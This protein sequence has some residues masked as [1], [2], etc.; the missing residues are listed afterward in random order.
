MSKKRK[1]PKR[2]RTQAKR[3]PAKSAES[4]KSTNRVKADLTFVV[5]EDNFGFTS[6]SIMSYRE[7]SPSAIVRELIQNSMDAVTE[8]GVKEAQVRFVLSTWKTADIPGIASYKEAFRRSVEFR[9][10]ENNGKQLPDQEQMIVQHIKSALE[11]KQLDVLMVYDNGIGLNEKTMEALLSDG[12]SKKNDGASGAFGNGHFTVFPV[13]DLRYV[14]YGAIHKEK[15]IASGHAILA[16][17][18]KDNNDQV[19]RSPNGYYSIGYEGGKHVYP[20]N[21]QI[22]PTIAQA[23]EQ[24][25]D[26]GTVIMVPAFNKFGEESPLQDAI[27]KATACSFFAAIHK[28]HL[29]VTIADERRDT[30]GDGA[31]DDAKPPTSVNADS[32]PGIVEKFK[33]KKRDKGFLPGSKA[34]TAYQ[35]LRKGEHHDVDLPDGEKVTVFLQT[36][37]V[38]KTRVNL[39]RNDMWVTNSDRRLP[40]FQNSFAEQQPFEALILVDATQTKSFHDLIRKAEGPLHNELNLK[41][42]DSKDREKLKTAFKML[43]EWFQKQVP[44]VTDDHYTPEDFLPIVDNRPGGKTGSRHE[45]DMAYNNILEPWGSNRSGQASASGNSATPDKPVDGKGQNSAKK[46]SGAHSTSAK[47]LRNH[48]RITARPA[49]PASG[50]MRMS[51]T[52]LKA[53]DNNLLYLCLDEHIDATTDHIWKEQFAAIIGASIDDVAVPKEDIL[54]GT[55]PGIKLGNL[56]KDQTIRVELRY[57]PETTDLPPPSFRVRVQRQKRHR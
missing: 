3:L 21:E 29:Q 40:H 23:L 27:E 54:S 36:E 34:F 28:R 17:H 20:K 12:A 56:E 26:H 22:H 19:R 50:E 45:P 46:D 31:Q 43:K 42:M 1:K 38:T 10:K 11:K 25:K 8:I 5:S 4:A 44:K 15:R 52:S 13:S 47:P 55:R 16:S 33:D 18:Q 57:R 39:C 2:K 14:L 41:G 30:P 48:F 6:A 32:L 53:S 7:C 35:C 24:I 51:I 9:K 37:G 49:D